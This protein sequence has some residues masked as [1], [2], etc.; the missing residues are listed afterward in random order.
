M[1]LGMGNCQMLASWDA[2]FP[3]WSTA[4]GGLVWKATAANNT[5]LLGVTFYNQVWVQ[6]P[7]ANPAQI[8]VSNA[9]K[10][11]VGV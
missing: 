9:G 7:K 3:I 8:A 10:G 6:D 2:E 1:F 11:V 5:S 4:N